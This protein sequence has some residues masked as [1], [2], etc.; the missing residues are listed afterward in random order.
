MSNNPK[1]RFKALNWNNKLISSTLKAEP[2][3]QTFLGLLD[4]NAIE[5]ADKTQGKNLYHLVTNSIEWIKEHQLDKCAKSIVANELPSRKRVDY[6]IEYFKVNNDSDAVSDVSAFNEFCGVGVEVNDS[7]VRDYVDK[8]IEDNREAIM[9]KGAMGFL[10]PLKEGLRFG[11]D[12][13]LI[14]VYN[15]LIGQKKLPRKGAVKAQNTQKRKESV[16]EDKKEEE[17]EDSHFSLKKMVAKSLQSQLNKPQILA[18]HKKRTGGKI[19][20]RF[21]PEPNGYLHIGH[22]KAI[23][24]NFRV[25]LENGGYTYLRYDDTNPTKEKQE[26]IDSIE[27]GVRWL[28]YTPYEITYASD[29]FPQIYEVAVKLIEKGHAF[30]CFLS[31]EEGKEYREAKKPSPWR[32]TSVEEN[33]KQFQLMKAGFYAEG[34]C[35]LR[36]KIDYLSNH[37]TLNDPPIYRIKHEPH[38]HVKDKW[39]IYPL[40]D[41]THSL[42]DNFEDI[43]HSLCTL[44]FDTRRELYYWSLDVL[45]MF[46][47]YVWEYSRLNITHTVLS[48]RKITKLVEEGLVIGWNDPRL[49]TLEG[50]KRRGYPA[51]AVNHFCDKVGVTR[52]GN[53]MCLSFDF[54]EFVMRDWLRKLCPKSFIV[55]KPVKLNLTNF[56]DWK[57]N[58]PT[59]LECEGFDHQLELSDQV[60]V[61]SS[62]CSATKVKKFWGIQPGQK[63]RLR[64]G[65]FI[66][67]T[68]ITADGENV[69]AIDAKILTMEEVGNYK[70]VKGILHWIPEGEAFKVKVNVFDRLFTHDFPGSENDL[71]DDV[72]RNSWTVLENSL[73]STRLADKLNK[74]SRY[75]F[76]RVGFF[77][78]DYDTDFDQKKFVFNR[79]VDMKNTY[80]P[81]K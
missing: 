48:K 57:A 65:P 27:S 19:I 29:Y 21:P 41:F 66:E 15:K 52:R 40:Y 45:D 20:T 1:D 2:L 3:T 31:K 55:L 80:K 36:A 63:V 53:D 68:N 8:F 58:N 61:D 42:C 70:K 12:G 54:F 46:K 25:A 7:Q 67:I 73:I 32:D 37:T 18:E 13:V 30:V 78:L 6:A 10:V 62:D 76:E 11:E 35:V 33:L 60:W 49:L 9:V 51:D 26:Y 43:T 75:Q 44:E 38:P 39:C 77:A 22:C 5:A 16:K 23:R 17:P 72:D 4:R 34:E 59:L 28:G 24:F 74:D 81:G 50:I 56:N 79:I 64:Y 14:K 69:T 47:P 71:L